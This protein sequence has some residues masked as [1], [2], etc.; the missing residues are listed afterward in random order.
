M[1]FE[2][3]VMCKYDILSRLPTKRQGGVSKTDGGKKRNAPPSP[4]APPPLTRGGFV[5]CYVRPSWESIIQ[6]LSWGGCLFV[7]GT[8]SP[9]VYKV[10]HKYKRGDFCVVLQH[11]LLRNL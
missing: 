2:K 6:L 3:Y 5:L 7:Y 4:T 1:G 9:V 11:L 8:S 10:K